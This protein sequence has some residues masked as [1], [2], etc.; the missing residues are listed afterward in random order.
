[1]QTITTNST[2][3]AITWPGGVATIA[4]RGTFGGGTLTMQYCPEFADPTD[5]DDWDAVDD[6]S[7]TAKGQT[8]ITLGPGSLR[9][10]LAGATNPNIRIEPLGA[11]GRV[12]NW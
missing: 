12:S 4:P 9:F 8:N 6:I 10:V 11:L 5:E 1:M 2:T 7:F 3:D